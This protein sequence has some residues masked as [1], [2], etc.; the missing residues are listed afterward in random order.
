M[1]GKGPSTRHT[2]AQDL[3]LIKSDNNSLDKEACQTCLKMATP[4]TATLLPCY[5]HIHS[6]MYIHICTYQQRPTVDEGSNQVAHSLKCREEICVN[7]LGAA[8]VLDIHWRRNVA[9]GDTP[10][11][12]LYLHALD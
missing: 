9:I 10:A 12:K 11:F 3:R 8:G 6:H 5:Q 7:S 4:A 1:S 2:C